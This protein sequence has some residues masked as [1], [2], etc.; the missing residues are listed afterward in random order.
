[1]ENWEIAHTMA[2][3]A[4]WE[5]RFLRVRKEMANKR[6]RNNKKYSTHKSKRVY[7][8]KLFLKGSFLGSTCMERHGENFP[9]QN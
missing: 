1:M 7:I 3:P 5:D 6:N 9:K 4:T 8:K 2:D